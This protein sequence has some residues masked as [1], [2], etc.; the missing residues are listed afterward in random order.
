MKLRYDINP[1]GSSSNV[2]GLIC[3]VLSQLQLIRTVLSD[4][5]GQ[6]SI[7]PPGG[8]DTLG[9]RIAAIHVAYHHVKRE[10]HCFR[11]LVAISPGIIKPLV[12]SHTKV[13]GMVSTP[14]LIINIL[15]LLQC[16]LCR[17][18]MFMLQH[19]VSAHLKTCH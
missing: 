6:T 18:F 5:A 7:V 9:N 14:A 12:A 19:I 1:I 4:V 2:L 16:V 10:L 13:T 15:I 3:T 17:I 11:Q 8:E